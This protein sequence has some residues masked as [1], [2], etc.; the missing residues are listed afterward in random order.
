MANIE[1]GYDGLMDGKRQLING[2]NEIRQKMTDLLGKVN[3]LTYNGGFTTEVASKKYEQS[4]DEW[5]KGMQQ[6]N[7]GA[8]E[9]AKFLDEVMQRYQDLDSTSIYGG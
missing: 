5:V 7:E 6:M 3:N 9:M 1:V 2:R 8:A 4:F